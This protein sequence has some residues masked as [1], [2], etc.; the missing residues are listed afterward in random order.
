MDKI[1]GKASVFM[2]LIYIVIGTFGYLTF[3]DDL[4][5]SILSDKTSGNILECDYKGALSI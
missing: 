4:E 3:A 2:V 5:N 1:V